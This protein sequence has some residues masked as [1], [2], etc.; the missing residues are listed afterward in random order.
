MFS[1]HEL[2]KR[3]D[4]GDKSTLIRT[5]IAEFR[6]PLSNSFC[7]S[8]KEKSLREQHSFRHIL[9]SGKPNWLQ[10][11]Q[12]VLDAIAQWRIENSKQKFVFM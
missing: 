10:K 8:G 6:L 12:I 1:N 7:Y 11:I 4:V 5:V 2:S 9:C 3:T